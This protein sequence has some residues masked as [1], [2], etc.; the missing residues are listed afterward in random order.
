MTKSEELSQI[1]RKAGEI[2]L[3]RGWR[4]TTV[5]SC[6]GG[7]IC[8][9]VTSLAGS[10]DWFECGMV[11]YSN[12]SKAALVGVPG[13]LIS[14]YGAVSAQV[15]EAMVSGALERTDAS[16]AVSV[17]GIAGPGGGSEE[18]PVG[19]VFMAWQFPGGAAVSER[20]HFHGDREEVRRQSVATALSELARRAEANPA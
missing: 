7:W 13:S 16:V 1:A 8:Q 19:T 15:A 18:K 5:E 17:T 9:V 12:T 10:S 11:T 14:S 4:L 20:F 3:E 6:T 2:L